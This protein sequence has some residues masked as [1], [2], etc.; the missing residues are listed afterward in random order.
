MAAAINLSECL[1]EIEL[2]SAQHSAVYTYVRERGYEWQ[3]EGIE[4]SEGESRG[5]VWKMT[6]V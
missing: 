5:G 3:Q 1:F 2:D 6:E 4:R